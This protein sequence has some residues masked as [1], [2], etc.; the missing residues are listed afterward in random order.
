MP[1][2]YVPDPILEPYKD[3]LNKGLAEHKIGTWMQIRDFMS[4][5]AIAHDFATKPEDFAVVSEAL[6][7]FALASYKIGFQQA[8]KLLSKKGS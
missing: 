7:V 8:V 2:K 1:Y 4:E 5:N 3:A 6:E